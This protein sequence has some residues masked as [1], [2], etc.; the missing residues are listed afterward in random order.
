MKLFYDFLYVTITVVID[1][2]EF[3]GVKQ[4]GGSKQKTHFNKDPSHSNLAP[5]GIRCFPHP[6][7][8]DF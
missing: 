2:L 6:L 7:C 4:H 5:N 8:G 1:K 3:V